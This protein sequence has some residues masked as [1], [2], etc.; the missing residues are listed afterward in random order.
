MKVA[1]F[2]HCW[3]AGQWREP[4]SEHL[5]ALTEAKF[6]GPLTVGLVGPKRERDL[7]RLIFAGVYPDAIFVEAA[8]GYERVTLAAVREYASDHDGAVMYA[9][10]KGAAHPSDLQPRWRRS[11]TMHVISPW[12]DHLPILEGPW[13]DAIGCFWLIPELW[14]PR[15]DWPSPFFGG[16]FWVAR[17]DYL[18]KL[19]PL[20]Q[21][22]DRFDDEL[23][24]GLGRPSIVDL[25]PGHPGVDEHPQPLRIG[26]LQ[27][28]VGDR[29]EPHLD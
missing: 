5:Y 22:N 15:E 13:V 23:W 14:K 28:P 4:V 21:S 11:M 10:T 18:R 19:P 26:R 1:H 29:L 2:Y 17:C 24:I 8:S 12:R 20:K 9:H 6:D 16:N 3:C 27:V 7:A 25:H